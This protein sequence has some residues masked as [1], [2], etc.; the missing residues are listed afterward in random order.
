MQPLGVQPAVGFHDPSGNSNLNFPL[1]PNPPPRGEEVHAM[2]ETGQRSTPPNYGVWQRETLWGEVKRRRDEA[3]HSKDPKAK[4]RLERL[5]HLSTAK[6]E[7][8]RIKLKEDDAAVDGQQPWKTTPL[9]LTP[10]KKETKGAK[11]KKGK[12][13]QP[14]IYADLNVSISS[15]SDI[16]DEEG[17]A[18]LSMSMKAR[19]IAICVEDP[20]RDLIMEGTESRVSRAALDAVQVRAGVPVWQQIADAFADPLRTVNLPKNRDA[21]CDLQVN[22]VP[23]FKKGFLTPARIRMVWKVS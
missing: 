16:E 15:D 1:A 2:V 14:D 3:K 12:N 19:I 6:K 11:G 4:E 17:C 18:Q 13:K 20:F 7:D 21:Y 8:L 10:K 5:K 9:G 22:D 23:T